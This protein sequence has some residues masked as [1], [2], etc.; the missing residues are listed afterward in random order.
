MPVAAFHPGQRNVASGSGHGSISVG[1]ELGEGVHH[2]GSGKS[3]VP[4]GQTA[5]SEGHNMQESPEP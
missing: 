5:R 3:K 1:N 4:P 2:P